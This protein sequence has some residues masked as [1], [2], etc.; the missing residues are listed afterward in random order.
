MVVVMI[1]EKVVAINIV[2]VL[3]VLLSD[4][5]STGICINIQ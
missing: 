5:N 3:L 2:V 4:I 1:V